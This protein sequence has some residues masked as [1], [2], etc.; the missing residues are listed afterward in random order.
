MTMKIIRLLI[1]CI[2]LLVFLQLANCAD[3]LDITNQPT[4]PQEQS[5]DTL[6]AIDTIF[7]V[8]TITQEHVDTL[9]VVD[10]VVEGGMDTII[11]ID[12]VTQ[13]DQDTVVFVDTVIVTDT[14]TTVDTVIVTNDTTRMLCGQIEASQKEIVWLIQNDAGE[15][16]L[17]FA[18]YLES[19]QPPQTLSVDIDGSEL[20]WSTVEESS[21]VL[22]TW[23]NEYAVIRICSTKPPARGHAVIVCLSLMRL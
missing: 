6:F 18:V 16:R 2:G 8:D 5:A 20:T 12:T 17:S 7:I 11:V 10:T 4:P 3:P 22:S 19:D 23:L 21:L 1:A 13:I 9:I 14:V 15:Y